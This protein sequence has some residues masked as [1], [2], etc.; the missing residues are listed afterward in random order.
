MLLIFLDSGFRA[1]LISIGLSN[2]TS[3]ICLFYEVRD[4]FFFVSQ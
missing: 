3:K 2:L 1:N 4:I